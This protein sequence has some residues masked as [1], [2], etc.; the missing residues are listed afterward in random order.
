MTKKKSKEIRDLGKDA[1]EKKLKELKLELVK[2]KS[3]ASKGGVGKI[4]EIKRYIARI[5]TFH[6]LSS[7]QELKKKT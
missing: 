7:K 6:T 1:K 5:N 2:A 3:N 4:K